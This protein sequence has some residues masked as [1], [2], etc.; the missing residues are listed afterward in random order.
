MELT[1]TYDYNELPLHIAQ[2]LLRA[3]VR[4]LVA[5]DD[6]AQNMIESLRQRKPSII[7]DVTVRTVYA[8]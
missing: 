7:Y 3:H 4:Q 8:P 6:Q 1:M 5:N 2:D